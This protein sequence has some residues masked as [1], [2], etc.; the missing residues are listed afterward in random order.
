MNTP[1]VTILLML[2]GGLCCAPAQSAETEDLFQ[3][4]GFGTLAATRTDSA[5]AGYRTYPQSSAKADEWAFD[6]DSLLGVQ[7]DIAARQA[8]SATLQVIGR[9]RE[10]AEFDPQIEWG[11]V[12]YQI[13]PNLQIRVGRVLTPV[14]MES[15][16][17][18]V[19]YAN[20][21]VRPDLS[22]YSAYPLSSHDGL[23]LAYHFPLGNGNLTLSGYAGTAKLSVPPIGNGAVTYQSPSLGGMTATWESES[24]MMR[25]GHLESKVR[26]EG[27]GMGGFRQ[28]MG[29]L[30]L[31]SQLGCASCGTE[32]GKLDRLMTESVMTIDSLGFRYTLAEWTLWGEYVSSRNNST[33]QTSHNKL[34]GV[35]HAFG[36]WTPYLSISQYTPSANYQAA[37]SNA[38]MAALPAALKGT[39]GAWNATLENQNTDRTGIAVGVRWDIAR[40]MALK[41]EILHMALA[42]ASANP[43]NFPVV[44]AVS[45]G[46]TIKRPQNFNLFT[47]ALDFVF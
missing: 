22:I 45:F 33:L 13:N 7:V 11:F 10:T 2:L 24:L 40:N 15:D 20:T 16:Y 8:L 14:F 29:A 41:T 25:Y 18:Y 6:T 32:A 37:I 4:R 47:L 23:N 34:I 42:N 3:V 27:A 5:T 17:R 31:S 19:G 26:I 46:T 38:D 9:K 12:N 30:A 28:L 39:A 1:S 21:F 35:S 43:N 36:A 44:P